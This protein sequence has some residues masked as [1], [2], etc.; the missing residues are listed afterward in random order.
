MNTK[1]ILRYA[2]RE[3]MG[4][5]SMGIALFWS[6]GRIDWW[7]AWAALAIMLAWIVATAMVILRFNPDLLAERLGPRKG[8]KRWD[9]AIMSMLGLVQL[10]RYILAGLDQRYDWTGGFPLSAQIVALILCVLG[11]ALVVW[12]TASNTFFSQI[13]RIQ[14]ERGHTVVTGGPYQYVRHP[15]YTGAI[16]YELA[17]PALFAS[18]WTFFASSLVA[19]LLILRTSLEDRTLLA[20][21]AGYTDYA[22]QVRFRLLPGIW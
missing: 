4:L 2:I 14:T 21:L 12:A 15:A 22:R 13:V 10:A 20:E 5:V 9:T 17:A 8:A 6:A 18:W 16:L 19:I 11:Y 7:P 3:I 1:L